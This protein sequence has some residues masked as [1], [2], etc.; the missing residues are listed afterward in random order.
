MPP[1]SRAPSFPLLIVLLLPAL[2]G[3]VGGQ[4]PSLEVRK[5]E[6]GGV[7]LQLQ[8]QPLVDHVLEYSPDLHQWEPFLALRLPASPFDWSDPLAPSGPQGFYRLAQWSAGAPRDLATDFRL[9]DHEGRTRHLMYH[10]HL[11]AVVLLFVDP[12]L[13]NSIAATLANL[14][15]TFGGQSVEFWVIDPISENRED[16]VA[17]ATEWQVSGP[18]LHDAHQLVSRAYGVSHGAEVVAI[19]PTS[20]EI[21]YRGAIER[22]AEGGAPAQAYLADALTAFLGGQSPTYWRTPAPGYPLPMEPAGLVS[23]EQTIAP[24]LIENCVRCHSPGNIAPFSLSNYD[25]V[26]ALAPDIR[27]AIHTGEMPPWFADPAFGKFENDWSLPKASARALIDWIDQG[28]LRGEGPDPLVE[29]F[30]NSPPPSDY[31]VNWPSELGEPDLVVSIP[32]ENIPAT[33]E[34]DYRYIELR[35]NIPADTYLR[36]AVI[37]P[38]NPAVVHHSLVFV[39]SVFETLIQGAGLNGYFAGYVPGINASA[40]PEGTGKLIRRNP[41]LTVQMHY[42]TNGRA[43]TDQTQLG[44]YFHSTPPN[45]E[46]RTTAASTTSINISPSMREYTSEASVVLSSTQSTVLYELSPHMHFRGARMEYDAIYPD[47]TTEKLLSVPHYVFDWQLLYR[48]AE[49]KLL[50]PGTIIRARGAFD[51]SA[52]NPDNPNPG[53]TVGFGEQSDDEMFIGYINFA[54]DR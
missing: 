35:P 33:G 5:S 20:Q 8:G 43:T 11:Q 1:S 19:D 48:L 52:Q 18:I 32:R 17:K 14:E 36:A 25:I 16:L 15:N 44:L 23:Y 24:L 2:I 54:I 21:F 6:A 7:D 13:D 22:E 53:A 26:S 30:A 50:P 3:P 12:T 42:Q 47:G 9:V 51:N 31:P 10:T 34:V 28:A 49:P 29:H 46:Y 27:H 45:K 4:L 39:G 37:K 40:F 38:G 41:T